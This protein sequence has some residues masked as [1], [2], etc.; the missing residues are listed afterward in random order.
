MVMSY[1]RLYGKKPLFTFFE[2][3][4]TPDSNYWSNVLK[5]AEFLYGIQVS[6][7]AAWFA[8]LN[9]KGRHSEVAKAQKLGWNRMSDQNWI[10]DI[11]II[12]KY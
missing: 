4:L 7:Y 8:A 5:I 12:S 10:M 2:R 11:L 3:A 9:I 6:G 1:S